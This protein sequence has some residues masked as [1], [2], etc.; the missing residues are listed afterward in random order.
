[1]GKKL[2]LWK[3]RTNSV[4]ETT[5][6]ITDEDLANRVNKHHAECMNICRRIE[7]WL[8]EDK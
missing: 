3:D 6:P 7:R 1:M 4:N 5:V 8:N 2:P